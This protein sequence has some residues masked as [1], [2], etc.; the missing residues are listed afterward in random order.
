LTVVGVFGIVSHQAMRRTREV[1]I[2]LALGASATRIARL[3]VSWTMA[4]AVGGC[5]AGV[6][7]A[8][9]FAP[10]LQTLLYQVAPRD[11]TM[12]VATAAFVLALVGAASAWPTLRASRIDPAITLRT[13]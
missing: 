11:G 7:A 1:G 9:W 6:A 4:P 8:L 3:M 10:W 5:L 13:E 12:L 2:R